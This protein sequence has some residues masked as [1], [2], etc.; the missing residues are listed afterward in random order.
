MATAVV[1][2][3]DYT[4]YSDFFTKIDSVLSGYVSSTSASIIGAF[5]GTATTLLMIYVA[6]WGW[7]MKDEEKAMESKTRNTPPTAQKPRTGLDLQII[8][9]GEK[10]TGHL[11]TRWT[12]PISDEALH[13][14]CSAIM[15]AIHS[16]ELKSGPSSKD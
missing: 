8:R 5:S 14:K 11:P 15:E 13:M 1:T 4:F 7:M 12:M 2:N 10:F 3:P 9:K 6:L 16:N